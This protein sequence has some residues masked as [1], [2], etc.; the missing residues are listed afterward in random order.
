M[1]VILIKNVEKLGNIGEEKEVKDG[2]ARNFLLSKGLAVMPGDKKAGQ[3]IAKAKAEKEKIGL[4][5]NKIAELAKKIS[6]KVI[7]IKAKISK[8]GKLFGSI[9]EEDIAKELKLDK[10]QIKMRP[11]KEVGEHLTEIDFGQ[12]I[13]VEVKVLVKAEKK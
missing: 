12:G 13:K 10:K 3:V 6:G 1:K 9:G 7:E 4:D 8:S 11:I 5:K 2:Y